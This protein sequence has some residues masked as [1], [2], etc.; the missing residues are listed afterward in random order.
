[1]SKKTKSISPGIYREMKFE[2]YLEEKAMSA[3]ALKL[4]YK[5]HRDYEKGLK[6]TP[7]MGSG[8]I[9]HLAVLENDLFSEITKVTPAKRINE[10]GK[11]VKFVRSGSHWEQFQKENKGKLI[12][13]SSDFDQCVSVAEAVHENPS[14]TECLTGEKEVS[15]FWADPLFG[16][17]KA[18]FDCLGKG[19]IADLKRTAS[20]LSRFGRTCDQLCY[21]IQ[22]YWYLRGAAA[23]G[24]EIN[25]FIFVAYESSWP[26][27]ST[28]Q[29]APEYMNESGR[30]KIDVAF[31]NLKS[32]SRKKF[33]GKLPGITEIKFPEWN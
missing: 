29:F 24:L 30:R 25:V 1:M 6:Q 21:D 9:E 19:F 10:K 13:S 28:V 12:I 22:S 31:K 11:E 15:I 14:A 27:D 16:P 20:D 17:S 4:L 3:S 7:S 26:H 2:D 23:V 8:R 32:H 18:R 33:N 5:S